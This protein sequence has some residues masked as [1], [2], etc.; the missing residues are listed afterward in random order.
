MLQ[1]EP[2]CFH[3]FRKRFCWAFVILKLTAHMDP[4]R[5]MTRNNFLSISCIYQT[6][7][8]YPNLNQTLLQPV[9]PTRT[10]SN[11]IVA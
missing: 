2:V 4:S 9:Q 3:D 11:H 7:P 1:Y 5:A 8:N 10:K 6:Y